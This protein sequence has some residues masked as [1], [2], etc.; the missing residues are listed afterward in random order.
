METSKLLSELNYKAIR[1]SGPGGQNVNKVSSKVVLSFDI[2]N[3][4]AFS[5]EELARLQTKLAKKISTENLLLLSCDED[6][7]QRKNKEI[8]TKRFLELIEK[9]LRVPKKRVATKVPKSVNEKRIKEKKSTA[10]IKQNRK[11]PDV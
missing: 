6:R 8:V 3:T 5:Q 1:S 7:S 11:K 4:Q 10:E 9:A 2:A